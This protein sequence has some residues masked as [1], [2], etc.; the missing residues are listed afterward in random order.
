MEHGS[1]GTCPRNH[2]CP[3]RPA[4]SSAGVPPSLPDAVLQHRMNHVQL[5]S[6]RKAPGELPETKFS[7][8]VIADTQDRIK[9]FDGM[10]HILKY[11]TS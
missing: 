8:L 7:L 11:S 9:R 3:C 4:W 6:A 10:F 5:F 1:E 2:L